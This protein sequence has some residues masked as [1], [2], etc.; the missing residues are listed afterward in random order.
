VGVCETLFGDRETGLSPD[1]FYV[2]G[3]ESVAVPWVDCVVQFAEQVE[4]CPD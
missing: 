1:V 3:I 4:E 2:A